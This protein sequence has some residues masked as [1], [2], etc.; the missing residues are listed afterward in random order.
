MKNISWYILGILLISSMNTTANDIL[1]TDVNPLMGYVSFVINDLPEHKDNIEGCKCE[2]GFIYSGDRQF[3][4]KCGCSNCVCKSPDNQG[5]V[6]KS[7]DCDII[8]SIYPVNSPMRKFLPKTGKILYVLKVKT[9]K[10][11]NNWCTACKLLEY[12]F[13]KMKKTNWRID[14][15][16]TLEADGDFQIRVV[17]FDKFDELPAYFTEFE[18]D[19]AG[20]IIMSHEMEAKSN[21]TLPTLVFFNDGKL[22]IVHKGFLNSFGILKLFEGKPIIKGKDDV[23]TQ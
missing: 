12:E 9:D 17:D 8:K 11:G 22:Q 4:K 18:R 13:S 20:R 16:G 23:A 2:N 21:V 7:S 6:I 5:S 10:D 1:D 3:K 14:D 19:K 15:E